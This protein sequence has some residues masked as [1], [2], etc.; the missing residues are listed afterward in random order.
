MS[1]AADAVASERVLI[2]APTG[3]DA[4]M[5]RERILADGMACEICPDLSALL[6]GISAG[7]GVAIIAQEA[8][9]VRGAEHLLTTL[10]AQEPWSDTPILFLAE[11]R[12]RWPPRAVP[13]YFERANVT[14]LQRPFGV[15]LFLS[16]VRSAVRARRRQYQMR[17]LYRE[18]E[19]ALQLGEMFVSIL[20]HDLRNP[21]G[22]IRMAAQAIVGVAPAPPVLGFANRIIVTSDRMT[23]MI[24]Q[25]LD[26]AR[27][28]R[29]GGI[30][31]H[32]VRMSLSD[33]CRQAIQEVEAA[34]PGITIRL[35]G[36]GA[37]DGVWDP[38]R[39]AQVMTNLLSN[40]VHHGTKGHPISV[41]VDGT[42][43]ST[44]RLRVMNVGTIPADALPELF[45]AFKRGRTGRRAG[46]G[47][48]LYIAREIV[49]AHGGDIMVST[50][51]GRVVFEVVLPREARAAVAA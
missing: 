25:L 19:R 37:P 18:L 3:R 17:D 43:P 11:I 6:D 44:V 49:R 16:S 38:D 35:R 33:L 45:D 10:T 7:A 15:Q 2:L 47:L 27:A 9:T 8:L 22:A 24:E 40:A 20:G 5:L 34:H 50:S 28:R 29:A 36:L 46:L 42:S 31:V 30:P 41:E 51:G 14:L 32:P 26:L 12:T 23:R 39:L 1:D 21:V 4:E 13:A 48:G